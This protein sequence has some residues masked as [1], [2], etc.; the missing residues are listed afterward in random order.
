MRNE[1][2]PQI[3]ATSNGLS[4]KRH[5]NGKNIVY[6]VKKLSRTNDVVVLQFL[7]LHD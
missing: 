7:V 2:K 3:L 4:E 1:N 5:A 6:K